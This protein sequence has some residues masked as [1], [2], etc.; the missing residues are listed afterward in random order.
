MT[1]HDDQ[2][3]VYGMTP[4]AQLE[5]RNLR[6]VGRF[7]GEMD[8]THWGFEHGKRGQTE[9]TLRCHET[10]LENYA[11]WWFGTFGLCFHILGI[12]IPTDYFFFIGVGQPPTSYGTKWR[13]EK[14]IEP[15]GGLSALHR[16]VRGF[17]HV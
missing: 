3:D 2:D 15:T 12:M 11:G 16:V 9:R 8:R 6:E 5:S 7:Y 17:P 13:A 4:N 14:I 1:P 10:W